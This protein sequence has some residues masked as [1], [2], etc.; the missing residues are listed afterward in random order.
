MQPRAVPQVPEATA[1]V[2]RAAFPKGSLPMTIRDQLG[3]VF[4]DAEFAGAFGVRGAPAESPAML[5][6]VTVLQFA[7]D[8]TDRQ[9]ADAV[10]G[11]IDWKY[12]LGLE[13]DDH[14]FDYTVLS[15]FRARVVAHELEEKALD[16]LLAHL[17]NKGLVKAGGKQ[18]TDSTH[19]LGA[20]RD[21]NR[22]EL[23]GECVRAA[24]EAIS[25]AAPGW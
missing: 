9:A 20:V 12:G 2:A 1:Q 25:A 13:L 3:E 19:V 14:G 4:T 6:L 21:L 10:R 7:E 18:R 8:L 22:L 11:R 17:R 23:A 15:K 24:L 16:A 5:A